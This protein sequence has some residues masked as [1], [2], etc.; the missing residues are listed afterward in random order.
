VDVEASV[1]LSVLVIKHTSG[2]SLV[3]LSAND[4]PVQY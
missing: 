2:D 4:S 1:E 3:R